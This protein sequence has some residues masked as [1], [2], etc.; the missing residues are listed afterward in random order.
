ML[1]PPTPSGRGTAGA[2]T[3][4]EL[5]VVIAIIAILAAMLLPALAKAK[6]SSHVTNCSSNYKQWGYACNVYATDNQRGYYPSF[7]MYNCTPGENVTD[8]AANFIS[9]MNP[10]GMTVPM[11]FCPT[12]TGGA[13]SFYAD[14]AKYFGSPVNSHHHIQNTGQL[15]AFY[16]NKNIKYVWGL[17]HSG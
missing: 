6:F 1:Q 14:D 5:L 3:L 15:S 16:T 13:N 10:Y 9:G 7:A 17:Y 12:R 2:F 11:Y 4:I 8:V